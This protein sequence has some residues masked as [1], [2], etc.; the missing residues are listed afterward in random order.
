M[1]FVDVLPVEPVT[2]TTRACERSRTARPRAAI[3][4]VLVLR[5]E[6]A[7]RPT[8]CILDELDATPDRDEQVARANSA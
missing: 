5:H 6:A 8:T 4:C 3:A 7:A 2:A 1:S